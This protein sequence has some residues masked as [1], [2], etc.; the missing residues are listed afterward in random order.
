VKQAFVRAVYDKTRGHCHFCGDELEFEA[1]GA[2]RQPYPNGAW[3]LDHVIQVAKR[4][5]GT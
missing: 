4:F 3:E 2:K 1:Y 5:P